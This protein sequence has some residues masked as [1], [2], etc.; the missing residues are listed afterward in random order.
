MLDYPITL[1]SPSLSGNSSQGGETILRSKFEFAT[2]QRATFCGDY[3]VNRSFLF[4][5]S[6]LMKE[7]KDFYYTGLFNGSRSFNADWEIEGI[8]GVKEFRFAKM[9]SVKNLTDGIYEVSASF[10]LVT[11]IKDL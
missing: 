2:R 1:P 11:K 10:E 8:T 4:K 3:Y 7:F 5:T 9:Y 6:A